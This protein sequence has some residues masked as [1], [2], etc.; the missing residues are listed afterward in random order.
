MS[1]SVNATW[2]RLTLGCISCCRITEILAAMPPDH[3]FKAGYWWI[4]ACAGL[5]LIQSDLKAPIVLKM[6]CGDL[7]FD[8]IHCHLLYIIGKN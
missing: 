1:N 4:A 5:I 8:N 2:G 7:I 3:D 6:R